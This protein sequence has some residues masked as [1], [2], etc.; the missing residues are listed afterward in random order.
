MQMSKDQKKMLIEAQ[1]EMQKRNKAFEN[2]AKPLFEKR[3]KLT[4]ELKK[5]KD[6]QNKKYRFIPCERHE[7]EMME[8]SEKLMKLQFYF[9]L[10]LELFPIPMPK[11]SM[12]SM[13]GKH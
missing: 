5:C 2:L 1:K 8:T 7:K 12:P 6:C 3:K 13:C 10:K 4:E 11:I 9:K